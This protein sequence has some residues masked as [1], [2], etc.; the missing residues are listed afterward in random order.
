MK[1]TVVAGI[2]V[3]HE[4]PWRDFLSIVLPSFLAL[5]VSLE[6]VLASHQSNDN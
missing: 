4:L 5:Y 3:A 2:C 6:L 1:V